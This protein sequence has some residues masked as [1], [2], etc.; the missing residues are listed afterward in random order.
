MQKSGKKLSKKTRIYKDQAKDRHTTHWDMD[1]LPRKD[2]EALYAKT[3]KKQPRKEPDVEGDPRRIGWTLI[4]AGV[5][6]LI[7]TLLLIRF[8][9]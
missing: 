7:L 8:M 5:V 9:V 6:L 4:I 2:V 3:E 1:Y